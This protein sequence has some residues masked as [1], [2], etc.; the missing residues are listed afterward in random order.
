[1]SSPLFFPSLLDPRFHHPHR[2]FYLP[3]TAPKPSSSSASN[4]TTTRRRRRRR[5][6]RSKEKEKG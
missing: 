1:M 2:I 3:P 4:I 5:R 6:K